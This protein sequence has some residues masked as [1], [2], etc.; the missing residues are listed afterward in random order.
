MYPN[1]GIPKDTEIRLPSGTV[2]ILNRDAEYGYAEDLNDP[3]IWVDYRLRDAPTRVYR[4]AF[5][6]MEIEAML[7]CPSCFGLDSMCDG[8]GDNCSPF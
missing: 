6:T 2:G 1:P 5:S 7:I 8:S 4:I 3:F